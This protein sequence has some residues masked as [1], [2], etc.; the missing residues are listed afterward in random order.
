MTATVNIEKI[1][2][3]AQA[4]G[5]D[6]SSLAARSG[7]SRQALYRFLKAEYQPFSRGFGAVVEAQQPLD[8]LALRFQFRIKAVVALPGQHLLFFAS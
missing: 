5:W 4:R 6:L 2:D 3:L 8:L 7:L 1:R